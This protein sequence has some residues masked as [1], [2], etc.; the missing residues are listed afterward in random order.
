MEAGH[1]TSAHAPAGLARRAAAAGRARASR[2]GCSWLLD[3]PGLD[4]IGVPVEELAVERTVLQPG[5]IE[6]HVRNDGADP[7]QVRQVIVNDGFAGVHARSDDEIGRLGGS[8]IDVDY[9]WI[10]GEA[11][12]V[13]LLTATGGDDRPLD[14]GGGRDAGRRPRLLRPDGADRPLRRRDPGGD[15]DALAAVDPRRRPSLDAVPAG[16]HGRPARLPRRRR[17]ARGHRD[18]RRRAPRRS[19]APRSSGSARRARILALAGVD[20]LAARAPGGGDGG[21]GRRGHRLPRR[22]PRGAR[23]RPAQPGR[24]AGDRLGLRDRVAGARRR[25]GR[26]LRAAQHHRG[27]G[28]RGAGRA[29]SGSASVCAG[30][31]CSALLAGAPAVLGAWIGASAFNP[32]LAAFMFGLGAGAIAQVVVQIAPADPRRRRAAC[33]TRSPSAGLLT[34][35]ARDV[36]DRAAGVALMAATRADTS[37]ISDAVQDYAKAIWSLG[38]R[39]DEPV[40]TSALAERLGRVAGVRVGD[41]QAARV[42]RARLARALPRRGAHAARAS[43]SRSR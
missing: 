18:R 43:A 7:V 8:E 17:P 14:R 41:G 12:E 29:R 13:A 5:E 2:S 37:E 23:H 15:R 10:E 21:G 30:S 28:D 9:P 35:L 36:R 1:R 3:A 40:S 27:P 22:V 38:Q 31:R 4:R 42:A 6:L 11:Y 32:S 20:A 34:G 24:G 33:C 26:R 16:A 25:A 19:A 39:T